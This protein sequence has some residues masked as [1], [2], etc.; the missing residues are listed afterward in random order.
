MSSDRSWLG[1]SRIRG[2]DPRLRADGYLG[3]ALR[4][5]TFGQTVEALVGAATA[6]AAASADLAVFGKSGWYTR[7]ADR[8]AWRPNAGVALEGVATGGANAA[9]ALAVAKILQVAATG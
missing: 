2:G 7:S 8:A 9:A 5:L 6:G 1:T 4:Y 3:N